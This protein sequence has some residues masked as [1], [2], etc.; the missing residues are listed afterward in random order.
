M[1]FERVLAD[2]PEAFE[3][4]REAAPAP[5][6]GEGGAQEQSA[7]GSANEISWWKRLLKKN[8]DNWWIVKK[9]KEK[10]GDF[11]VEIIFRSIIALGLILIIILLYWMGYL[12]SAI[13]LFERIKDKIF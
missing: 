1:A 3:P 11:I 13:E 6:E 4:E 8:V 10:F 7:S 5:A 9:L 2:Y 12:E